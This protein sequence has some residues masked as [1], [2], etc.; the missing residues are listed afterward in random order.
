MAIGQEHLERGACV[1][2][3]VVLVLGGELHPQKGFFLRRVPVHQRQLRLARAGVY[4]VQELL[5]ARLDWPQRDGSI[6]AAPIRIPWSS[7]L[8]RQLS[9]L[10]EALSMGATHSWSRSPTG[11]D[12]AKYTRPS[13]PN[14]VPCSEKGA[15]FW[16]IGGNCPYQSAQPAAERRTTRS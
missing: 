9:S 6:H 8:I 1:V 14:V 13:P 11:S 12:R 7:S 3:L 15:S 16:L 10:G 4:P 2:L 5:V